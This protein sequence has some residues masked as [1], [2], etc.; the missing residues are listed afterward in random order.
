MFKILKEMGCM[1]THDAVKIYKIE[2]SGF[3]AVDF[4]QADGTNMKAWKCDELG[5]ALNTDEPSMILKSVLE[6][7]SHD[8]D[9]EPEQWDLVGFELNF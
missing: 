2:K 3:L 5:H 4:D 8:K 1:E 9:G 7:V 6:P